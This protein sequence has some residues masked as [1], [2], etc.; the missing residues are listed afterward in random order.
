M[1]YII[2]FIIGGSN[3]VSRAVVL[4]RPADAAQGDYTLVVCSNPGHRQRGRVERRRLALWA[5]RCEHEQ[6]RRSGPV[7]S[8][9]SAVLGGVRLLI[10][11][12]VVECVG[13]ILVEYAGG[14]RRRALVRSTERDHAPPP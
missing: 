9:R 4:R 8:L 2:R 6:T 7:R 13:F 12:P 10:G 3:T 14:R 5:S 1:R 11:E